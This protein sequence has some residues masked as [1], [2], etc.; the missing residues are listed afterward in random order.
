M[1]TE[2]RRHRLRTVGIV[3]DVV[4]TAALVVDIYATWTRRPAPAAPCAC[5]PVAVVA[6]VAR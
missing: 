3:L 4:L 2:P 5:G 1:E 6:P